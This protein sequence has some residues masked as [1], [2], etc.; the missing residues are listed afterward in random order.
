MNPIF[1]LSRVSA[2][3]PPR[4]ARPLAMRSARPGP[5]VKTTQ[6]LCDVVSA[7]DRGGFRG[8][9]RRTD[10]DDAALGLCRLRA[11]ERDVSRPCHVRAELYGGRPRIRPRSHHRGA[12]LP[13]DRRA[14]RRSCRRCCA[15]L[16]GKCLR[17]AAPQA[18]RASARPRRDH[19][20]QKPRRDTPPA[21]DAGIDPLRAQHLD[22]GRRQIRG[23]SGFSDVT[24]DEAESPLAW[25]ARR[26]GRDGRALIEPVQL[27]AGERLR[28]DF[29]R[30]HLM[31]RIT[32][33]WS[34]SVATGPRGASP[35]T[36]TDAVI[37]ARQRVRAA[38]DAVGPEFAGLLLDV[39]CFLKGL[40]DV[41]RERGWPPR[42]AK[43]VLQLGLDR[44]ARHY[45][46][47]S[48][49]HGTRKAAVRTWLAD[50]AQFVVSVGRDDV[51]SAAVRE[52]ALGI[53]ADALD[54]GAEAVRALRREMLAQPE[55]LEQRDRVG[56]RESRW[57]A[58]PE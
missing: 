6:R 42:S 45:G 30:A 41:E 18:Q 19:E 9:G 23:E 2:K 57:R 38:L 22:L 47:R 56:R 4:D 24:V 33:N 8:A 35:A 54:H 28:A 25:L 1:N 58:L 32:S 34:A 15:G 44:L 29:T 36:F 7:R 52:R 43:V 48:E 53:A 10:L 5:S 37:G 46:L 14:P 3:E 55:L 40:E 16:A 51:I 17:H 39:C 20:R 13:I 11:A 12:R 49:A 21:G 50:D 26:K 27:Q 31:P